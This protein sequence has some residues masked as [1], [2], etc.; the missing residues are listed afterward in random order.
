M[1]TAEEGKAVH[2]YLEKKKKDYFNFEKLLLD[3]DVDLTPT[4]YV[5]TSKGAGV[6]NKLC[7][8]LVEHLTC[9]FWPMAIGPDLLLSKKV[10]SCS[11][12]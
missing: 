9:S 3:D 7:C 10:C 12:V 11:G 5:S 8:L 2:V 6:I 1:V 4:R